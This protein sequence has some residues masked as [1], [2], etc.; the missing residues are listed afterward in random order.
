VLAHAPRQAGS[1]ATQGTLCVRAPNVLEGGGE[2]AGAKVAARGPARILE[3]TSGGGGSRLSELEVPDADPR[4]ARTRRLRSGSSSL[5]APQA[6]CSYDPGAVFLEFRCARGQAAEVSEGL[7]PLPTTALCSRRPRQ[8]F[9]RTLADYRRG[10]SRE[11]A[12]EGCGSHGGTAPPR[13]RCEPTA[14]LLIPGLQARSGAFRPG[15]DH[16][17]SLTTRSA[18][19][20]APSR[21]TGAVRE[22]GGSDTFGRVARSGASPT[23]VG[24]LQRITADLPVPGPVGPSTATLRVRQIQ[25]RYVKLVLVGWSTW[26]MRRVHERGLRG[27]MT[28]MS[29]S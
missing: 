14:P 4:S 5:P 18:V 15:G 2:F 13:A 17:S 27:M 28:R 26:M 21:S 19:A 25:K 11:G 23:K 3:Q 6:G 7:G 16:C 8:D 9:G 1:S 12:T 24:G 20:G 29:P 22:T 10:S